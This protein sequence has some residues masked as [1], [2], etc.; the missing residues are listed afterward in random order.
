S[1]TFWFKDRGSLVSVMLN[2][3]SFSKYPTPIFGPE[4]RLLLSWIIPFAFTA[5]YPAALFLNR[6]QY[7]SLAWLTPAVALAFLGA[8]GIV[9]RLGVRAYES[10]GS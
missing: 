5:F 4:I 10:T 7:A 8:A 6:Q 1:L 2:L 3:G 9:W